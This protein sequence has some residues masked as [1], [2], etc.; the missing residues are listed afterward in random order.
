MD[1]D[2][3]TQMLS[4]L[5]SSFGPKI[6]QFMDTSALNGKI[7]D[8]KKALDQNYTDL[9]KSTYEKYANKP[10]KGLE[11]Q[12]K[13]VKE[14]LESVN[15]ANAQL[16]AAKG[17]KTCPNCGQETAKEAV[18]CAACGTKLPEIGAA[19][20]EAPVDNVVSTVYGQVQGV[21]ENGYVA[22]KGIPFAQ[23]PVGEL[24]FKPPVDPEGWE[25]V[26]VC[27]TYG[28]IEPRPVNSIGGVVGGS[29][30]MP[31]SEDCLYLNVYTP[32]VDGKKRP[33]LFNIHGGAFQTG[34]HSLN[35]D[36][37]GTT[38]M[39]CVLVT[40][41]YRLGVLGF[42]QL[43][44]YLGE[45]YI[46]SGNSGM[47]DIIKALE[48]VHNNI[49]GFGG[50]PEK[51]TVAGQSAGAKMASALLCSHKAKGLFSAVMMD[52]GATSAIRDLH[53]AQEIAERF[54]KA[55]G[56]TKK[57]AKKKLLDAPW[58]ELMESQGVLF[59]GPSL[60]NLGPV[61]DGVNFDG[62][63]ALEIIRS[64]KANYVTML[65]GYNRDE[66][67]SLMAY[68]P[69]KSVDDLVGFFGRNTPY[70]MSVLEKYHIEGDMKRL[71]AIISRYFYGFPCID[72]FDAFAQADQGNKMYLYRFDWDCGG[73]GAGHTLCSGIA[74]GCTAAQAPQVTTFDGYESVY[75]QTAAMWNSFIKTQDPNV[76]ELPVW[77]TYDKETRQAM[78]INDISTVSE[79]EHT[80]PN[81]STQ[82]LRL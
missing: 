6:Q 37:A 43:D 49:E 35:S 21:E 60:Q 69:M 76:P 40:A 63:D 73:Q 16:Q 59:E 72:M 82:T 41:S 75:R 20:A 57:N 18:C 51:V 80:D 12:F 33:V 45:E 70:I 61:F 31:C 28:P 5:G 54:A 34:D 3:I 39:D 29:S 10:L 78:F 47:L 68:Y 58:E 13:A 19:P 46:Q 11:E 22:F 44:R 53:T 77:P 79:I 64:G 32:A 25:G 30:E 62:E 27:D 2:Q 1:F 71:V 7:N 8:A 66:Y 38:A 17:T 15:E 52:S 65:G 48:W 9:G 36:P 42:L 56:V 23:P 81:I 55:Y 50:D 67:S 26:K 14:A 24:R 4:Q 74:T